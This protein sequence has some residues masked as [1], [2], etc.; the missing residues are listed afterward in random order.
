MIV[1]DT[2]MVTVVQRASGEAY[3]RLMARLESSPLQ[4][5]CVTLVS[6]EEQSRGWLAYIA[7]SN[8]LTK[9]IQAYSRL[10]K[11]L[12]EYQTYRILDFDKQA[13]VEYDHLR[14]AKIRIGT[15]DLRIAG[16]ALA[17]GATLVSGNL[18]DF[19]KV[20]EL[21]VEDWTADA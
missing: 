7:R 11:L 4:P 17:H 6:F 9:Q 15:M 14:K 12:Q 10:H 2:D 18:T 13:A 21:R 20:P 8:T 19:R 3:A 5:I 16:I 1:L